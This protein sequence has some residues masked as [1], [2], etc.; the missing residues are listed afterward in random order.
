ML[1]KRV[2]EGGKIRIVERAKIQTVMKEQDF[3][4]SNQVKQGPCPHWPDPQRR[5]LSDGRHCRLRTT[6]RPAG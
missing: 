2:A 5:C 3:G 6:T 1:T 4:A